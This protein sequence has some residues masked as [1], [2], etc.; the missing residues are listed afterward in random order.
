MEAQFQRVN[1]P[2]EPAV[3]KMTDEAMP[4]YTFALASKPKLNNHAEVQDG[5]RGL[6]FGNAPD[7]NGIPNILQS[8]LTLP[9]K[10]F[11]AILRLKCFPPAWKHD[12]VISILK[13]GK[14]QYSPRLIEPFVC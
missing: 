2:S 12:R 3:I 6:K 14:D 1:D 8:V 11:K 7:P 5:I 10:E 4:A 13:P 9:V